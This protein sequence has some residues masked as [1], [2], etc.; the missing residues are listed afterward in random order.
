MVRFSVGLDL[1]SQQV[2]L[3]VYDHAR[4]CSIPIEIGGDKTMPA[5]VALEV[6]AQAVPI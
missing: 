4:Q 1:G 6:C 3:A 5:C 2:A